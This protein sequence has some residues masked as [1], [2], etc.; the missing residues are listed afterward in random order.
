VLLDREQ[1]VDAAGLEGGDRLRAKAA[2]LE[3]QRLVAEVAVDLDDLL[4]LGLED[5]GQGRAAG[6]VG[7]DGLVGVGAVAVFVELGA[8]AAGALVVVERGAGG[9]EELGGLL[10]G[11]SGDGGVFS[12]LDLEESFDCFLLFREWE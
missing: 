10:F 8:V 11:G 1:R 2:V 12:E 3:Q 9:K 4:V 5:R 6:L 7:Q